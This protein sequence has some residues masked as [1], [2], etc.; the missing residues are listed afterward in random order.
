MTQSRLSQP[1]RTPAR[2]PLDQLAERD[3]H[4]LFHVA[5]LLH[6]ALDAEDLGAASSSA[7]RSPRTNRRPAGGWSA[8]RRW[9][10][11]CSPWSARRRGRPP[12]GRAASAAACPSCP[13]AT[14]SAPFPR[15]RCRRRRRGGRRGRNPSRCR[16]RWGRAAPRRSTRRSRPASRGARCS[17]R[18]GRRCSRRCAPIATPAMRQ[19]SARVCGSCRRMSR[20]LQV[21]GSDSSAFTTR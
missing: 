2:V 1:P 15:R 11:R 3:A 20:S 8:P 12:P 17:T 5:G 4:L 14:R 10:R 13:P 18:R 16:R 19:P 7:A 9:S 6:M 21:P